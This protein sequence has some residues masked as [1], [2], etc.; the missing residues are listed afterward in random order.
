MAELLAGYHQTQEAISQIQIYKGIPFGITR[1]DNWIML[2]P[3]DVARWSHFAETTFTGF[4]TLEKDKLNI[5][6]S[7]WLSGESTTLFRQNINKMGIKLVDNV[8]QI[9]PL[10]D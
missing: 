5:N 6:K 3:I 10:L 8:H 1:T 2:L 4:N 7:L 9:L